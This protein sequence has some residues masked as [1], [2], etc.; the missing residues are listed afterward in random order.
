MPSSKPFGTLALE[1]VEEMS[2]ANIDAQS[3]L[4]NIGEGYGESWDIVPPE[5][6]RCDNM[7]C[8]LYRLEVKPK[9]TQDGENV[10]PKCKES[11][12]EEYP[13]PEDPS[14][15]EPM[16]NAVWP[17]HLPYRMTEDEAAKRLNECSI[18]MCL[19][20]IE[21]SDY[22]ESTYALAMTGGGMD[23]SWSIAAAYIA[24]NCL[25]P[26]HLRLPHYAGMRVTKQLLTVVRALEQSNK[27]LQERTQA[28]LHDIKLVRKMLRENAVEH[29]KYERE[30]R[31]RKKANN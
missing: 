11:T 16:M 25:P 31:Q 24:L 27:E 1:P 14:Y 28:N 20:R 23:M 29:A 3:R 22:E 18:S 12:V 19:I 4:F 2:A 30:V 21:G 6:D 15:P 17:I 8:E 10:C 7:E 5:V 13:D 9:V 26:H